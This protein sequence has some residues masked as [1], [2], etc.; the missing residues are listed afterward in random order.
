MDSDLLMSQLINMQYLKLQI[1]QLQILYLNYQEK[2][3]L[4]PLIHTRD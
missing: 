1:L 4:I 2:Q 3:W